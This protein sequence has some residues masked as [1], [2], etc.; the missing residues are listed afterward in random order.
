MNSYACAWSNGVERWSVFHDAQQDIKHLETS[1]TLPPEIQ[2]IRDK[3]FAQQESDDGADFIFD[4]PVELFA[5]MG[6][7][8]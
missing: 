8:R 5:A 7:I 3:L 6:G 2:P 4:I 1:G